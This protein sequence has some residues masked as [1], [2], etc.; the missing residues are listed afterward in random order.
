MTMTEISELKKGDVIS[1]RG[2]YLEVE[3]VSRLRQF[4][5]IEVW[6]LEPNEVGELVRADWDTLLF[7]IPELVQFVKEGD[8]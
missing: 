2:L 1:N 3:D 6:N 8:L 4:G 7:T 5:D